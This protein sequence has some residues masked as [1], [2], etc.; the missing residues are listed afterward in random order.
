MDCYEKYFYHRRKWK[1]K[2]E[3][4]LKPTMTYTEIYQ[5]S[6]EIKI[7]NLICSTKAGSKRDGQE[8]FT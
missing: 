1:K 5:K 6:I 4:I 3:I 7:F 8:S 2:I